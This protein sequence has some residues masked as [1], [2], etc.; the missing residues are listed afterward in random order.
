[1]VRFFKEIAENLIHFLIWIQNYIFLIWAHS[2][3]FSITND[4]NFPN[5]YIAFDENEKKCNFILKGTRISVISIYF[6]EK[7]FHLLSYNFTTKQFSLL[8]VLSLCN[9]PNFKDSIIEEDIDKKVEEFKNEITTLTHD[10]I[11]IESE[12]LLR[13]IEYNNSRIETSNSKINFFSA[14]IL[15][16][17]TLISFNSIKA[18][19]FNLSAY[20][21][22]IWFLLYFTINLCALLIQSMN[23]RSYA[24][25]TF[26]KLRQSN[27]KKLYYVEQLY[28]EYLYSDHKAN[29][30]VSFVH[31]TYDY[32][33]VIIFISLLLLSFIFLPKHSN[34]KHQTNS[35]LITLNTTEYNINYT[36]D[37]I[38][39]YE[40]LLDL[41][42]G[43]YSRV[44]VMTKEEP[45]NKLYETFNLFDKQ[46]ISY[47]IDNTLSESDIKIIL[48]N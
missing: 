6:G 3:V 30:F 21:I 32:V 14:I 31:R 38:Q 28:E 44:I 5:L 41:K 46:K 43:L 4:L 2:P 33:K 25:I 39:F 34:T 27:N 29:F 45:D 7:I 10:E 9:H 13:K 22:L 16:I 1:M 47:I 17:I 8:K 20:N 12:E 37:N 18:L 23:V 42:K 40:T 15:A 26:T 48:E 24:S 19:S 35:K 36:D 11:S